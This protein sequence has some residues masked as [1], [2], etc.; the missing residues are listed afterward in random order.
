MSRSK[1]SRKPGSGSSGAVKTDTKKAVTPAP[2]RPK[3]KKGKTAG[4]RQQEAMPVAK[5]QSQTES[6][7]DPRIGSKKLIDLGGGV[8]INE[9]KLAPKNQAR[10]QSSPIAAIRPVE[11]KN[12]LEQALYEIENDIRLQKILA[13]QDQEIALSEE[14]VTLFNEL[15][16]K[17]QALTEEL[18]VEESQ[19]DSSEEAP[20]KNLGSDDWS[21]FKEE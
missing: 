15:M 9:S 13:K 6:N 3:I 2:R 4:N 11:V 12:N 8:S 17:H 20:W 7:K 21:D 5:K 18:G 10:E 1:K 14:E 19:E 16:E